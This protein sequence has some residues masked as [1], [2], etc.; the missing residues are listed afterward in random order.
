MIPKGF[1]GKLWYRF[2]RTLPRLGLLA[3]CSVLAL[4]AL[5]LPI[6][7]RPSAINITTGDVSVQDVQAPRTLTYTSEILSKQAKDD[8]RNRVQPIFLPTD[9]AITRTQIE[10]LRVALNYITVVRYDSFATLDQKIADLNALDGVAF[11]PETIVSILNLS[12]GRWQTVQQESLSVL[13]QAMRRTIRSDQVA[14]ARRSIPTLINFSLPEDHALVVIAVVEPFVEAN[15]L[16]SQEL[17]DKAREEAAAAVESVSRTFIAGETITRRGQVITPVVWEA[18]NAYNLIDTDNRREEIY[19]AVALVGLMSVFLAL[20]FYR[21]RMSPVENF[22][23]LVVLS[24]TFLI[25][26][27]GSRIII[28]NRTIMPYVFPIAAFALTLTSLYNLE[29]GLIFP[30]VL[31]ILAGY[32]LPNSL[33]LTIFYIITGMVGVLILGKGRRIANYFWAGLAIGVAG[34]AVILAYR[35]S[36]A[37]TDWVG[38]ATLLGAAFING[39]A[40]AGLS[41]LLQFLLSHLLGVTTALQL[42]DLMRPDHPLLQF[43]LRNMPGSYQHSLQVANLAEQAAETLG[44]DPLLTRAGAIFHDAGKGMNPSFFIENQVAGKLD[45]H[46]ELE[47]AKA[48]ATIIQHIYDGVAL[49]KKYRLPPRIQDF[50]RE[51]HGTM[52]TRYQ[53]TQAVEAAGGDASAVDMEQ[54]RYPGPSPRSRETALLMLADGMEARS[55]SE[56]PKDENELRIIARKVVDYCQREQQ[57]DQ[58]NLT[59]R[60]LNIIVESFVKTLLT[61]YHP[62]IRYPELRPVDAAGEASS[63][64]NTTP[65]NPPVV[66]PQTEEK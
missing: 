22:R 49:C 59:L 21:R 66:S 15:S 33:D 57:L 65:I 12:D 4:G 38:L 24:I 62:R 34:S 48:A 43:M 5:V 26:L 7:I 47:P 8:A 28:P 46:D 30:L 25:F 58:T 19:A 10:K 52:L 14:E 35:L 17:T 9:P 39:L 50:V 3:V 42:M 51:H 18:L 55:R 13:E 6:A 64:I 61:T 54:F 44:A 27:Y 20:Y 1:W 41:L 16:Y 37:I 2:T 53:Y 23:A 56:L 36:D 45:S 60:D 32:G 40:S 31:S 29:A 63:N 11:E